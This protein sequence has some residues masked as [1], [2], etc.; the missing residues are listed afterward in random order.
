MTITVFGATGQLGALVLPALRE[1]GVPADQIRAVGRNEER[2][3]AL[4]AEGFQTARADLDDPS[5]VRAAVAGS[6]RVL[7]I[8]A[9]EPGKRVPQHRAVIDTAATEGV[10]Q[11]VY[12]SI[13]EADTSSHVL[14]P[15]HRETEQLI[16]ASGL[17][18]TILRNN[19]YTENHQGDF[20]AVKAAGIIANSAGDGRIA[21]APRA[22][23][24]EAAAVVLTDPRHIGKTYELSG[25]TAWSFA[26]FAEIASGVL[27]SDVEYREITVE[28]EAKQ[29]EG[30]GLPADAAAFVASFS[31]GTRA[32]SLARTS[33]DLKELI[34]REPEALEVTLRTW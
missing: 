24:A 15:E 2:L 22:D 11:L 33:S 29:L 7:L 4:A 16:A 10:D 13:A 23:Y 31:Q 5:S 32:G 30:F 3:A 12:T 8:S 28:E 34:G 9:S 19:W 17:P 27:G 18:A 21:S 14:A 1:H 25:T 6:D 20:A 26:E